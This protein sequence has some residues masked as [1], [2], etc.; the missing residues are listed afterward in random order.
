[1]R[2]DTPRR[3][4]VAAEESPRTRTPSALTRLLRR[5]EQSRGIDPVVRVVEPLASRI[6]A[7]E[8]LRRL[9]HGEATGIPLHV[10]LTDAPLGA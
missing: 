4:D 7:N 8:R 2:V 10:I 5:L 3:T 1:M 9:L 6:V